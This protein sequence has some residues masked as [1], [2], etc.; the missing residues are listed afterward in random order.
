MSQ[1]RPSIRDVA[2]A[3]GVSTATVS[4]VFTGRKAVNA[5]LE[6]R[7]RELAESMGYRPNR[8]AADLRSGRSRVVTMLVPDLADPHFTALITEVESLA[9]ADGFELLVANAK[10]DV[11]T[12]RRRLSAL[13]AWQPAGLILVP[14]TDH[15]PPPLDAAA[16]PVPTVIADRGAEAE[17][18]DSVR[19]DNA[20][21]G[22]LAARHLLSLGHRRLLLAA[23]DQRLQAI[24]AR[25]EG[26][27]RIIEAVGG[28][29]IIVELGSDPEQGTRR[30][31]EQLD[32]APLPSAL[33]AV[34]D[35]TTLAVLTCLAE[36]QLDPGHDLS[37][38]GFDDY[39][40][41]RARRRPITAVAQP[42]AAM[43]GAI[44]DRLRR[45]M[46]GNDDPPSATVLHCELR[47][48]ASTRA[49]GQQTTTR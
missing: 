36:R 21:A 32:R 35:M 18:V 33:I 30:L 49:G 28:E 40:W 22:G 25:C 46:D 9:G 6:S 34:T 5:A 39:P 19:I 15:L 8:A 2:R 38:V 12:E 14:C 16:L 3:A 10:N 27:R 23:S 37:L 13:L 17:G 48:R 7:I 31:H 20:E 44:W 29:A 45:R 26:A 42:V 47:Q 4:N 43:A 24:R 1:R 41:M 11:G